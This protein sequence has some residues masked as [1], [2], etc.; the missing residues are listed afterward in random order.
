MKNLKLDD[1]G[2]YICAATNEVGSTEKVFF[3][4]IVDPP[5]IISKFENFSV[6]SK[7]TT[8][9]KCEVKG[10]PEPDVFWSFDEKK[11]QDG[12]ELTFNASMTSGLYSCTAENSAGESTRSLSFTA[13]NKPTIIEDHD[14]LKKEIKLR[15]GDGL[16]LLCPFEN[17]NQI[18]WLYNNSTIDNFSHEQSKNR[19]KLTKLDR[20]VGG[21][22]RCI[23]SNIAG[24]ATFSFN[25]TVLASPIIHASW[26]LNNRVS[27]FLVTDSDIDEKILKVGET[28]KLNCTA[29]G[30]PKPKVVWRKATDKISEGET[31]LVENLQ[32]HHSDIYT[33]SA[34]NDQGT[35][36]KFFKI[37][38]VS[39]PQIDD[40][41]LPKQYLKAVGESVTLH[42]KMS[43]NPPPNIFWFK[44][45]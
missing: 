11:V 20:S 10:S 31:L 18:A 4:S 29:E 41:D 1:W 26:N 28:L 12:P 2:A 27:D 6:S 21:E 24:T 9:V 14:E 34:E 8:A 15:E 22:W 17:F 13:I 33:C 39:P 40:A 37:D 42:C 19:L 7:E 5:S 43:G 36:K 32:F 23:A 45:K 38:V 25:V 16:E 44:D 3:L 30:F 35:V